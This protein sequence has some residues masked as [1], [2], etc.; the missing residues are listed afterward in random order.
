MEQLFLLFVDYIDS[1]FYDGYAEQLAKEDPQRYAWEFKEF[2][3]I[4]GEQQKEDNFDYE[5]GHCKIVK[6]YP[7]FPNVSQRA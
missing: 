2:C 5:E 4:N 6:M 1:I 3:W 7:D